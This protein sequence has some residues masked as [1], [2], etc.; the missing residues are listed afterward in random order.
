MALGVVRG[1]TGAGADLGSSVGRTAR[2]ELWLA[3]LLAIGLAVAP[4]LDGR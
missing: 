1:V 4:L 3:A 2:L